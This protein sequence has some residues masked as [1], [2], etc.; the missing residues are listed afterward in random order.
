MTDTSTPTTSICDHGADAIF[1]RGHD[2][3]E[4]LI[5]GLS[6]S[7]MTYLQV[8]GTMPGPA[9]TAIL[10]AV[11]V[12]LMEHGLTP[13][14]ISARL[15]YDSAPEALQGAVAGG[16]LAVGSTFV[17]TMEGAARLLAEIADSPDGVAAASRQVAERHRETR[18]PL[19]GFGHPIH[20]PDDPRTPKLLAL[21][22]AQ[23]V[24]GRYIAALRAL[25]EAVDEV[26]G[27]HITINATGAIAALLSEIRIP[28]QVMRGFA[29]ISRA[30]GLV[31]HILEE[32]RRPAARH[33]WNTAEHLKSRK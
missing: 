28:W 21:A 26:Y 7:E 18:T 33:I 2:L 16:L 19:P 5:G 12:T 6:F 17:G 10:D 1:V 13:S 29:V 8:M 4:E 14:A 9:E 22:E 30:A 15:I 23:N 3:V 20:R 31:G 11:L 25:G 24:E 32:Q 27:K